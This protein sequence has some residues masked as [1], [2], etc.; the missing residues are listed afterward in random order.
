MQRFEFESRARMPPDFLDWYHE[1]GLLADAEG[2]AAMTGVIVQYA[3]P[4]CVRYL[5]SHQPLWAEL[6]AR[7]RHADRCRFT[8]GV[9]AGRRV[10][11]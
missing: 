11:L 7:G 10:G 1:I 5:G 6:V 8:F 2:E 4:E 3:P 9:Y